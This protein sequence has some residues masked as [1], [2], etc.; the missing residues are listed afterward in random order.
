MLVARAGD[1]EGC[2]PTYR[3]QNRNRRVFTGPLDANRS[4]AML[5]PEGSGDIEVREIL[6]DV[7]PGRLAASIQIPGYL[8][9]EEAVIKD[10]TGDGLG[11]LVLAV[12]V[13]EGL[14]M[15]EALDD[16]LNFAEPSLL[17]AGA[18][19]TD[20]D[21]ADIDG[22]THVDIATLDLFTSKIA[23]LWGDDEGTFVE[24][25]ELTLANNP[26]K[27]EIAQLDGAGR[28]DI[29]VL[30]SDV[31]I[32]GV[33]EQRQLSLMES[34]AVP[35]F[36]SRLQVIDSAQDGRPDLLISGDTTTV[37]QIVRKPGLPAATQ[38]YS[39][40][41]VPTSMDVGDV[42]GDGLDDAVLLTGV[43]TT[44]LQGF[45]FIP[46]LL[47]PTSI[48]L[49]N[50]P[51]DAEL[52]DFDHDGDL[53]LLYSANSIQSARLVSNTGDGFAP[54]SGCASGT[55]F[56]NLN[57]PFA[58]ITDPDP[59]FTLR[60]R[61]DAW[62]QAHAGV[63]DAVESSASLDRDVLSPDPACQRTL[64]VELRDDLG[65]PISGA[66]PADLL[67]EHDAASAGASAI[68]PVESLG[69]GRFRVTLIGQNQTGE[70]VLRVTVTDPASGDRIVLMPSVNLLVRDLA[71]LDEDGDYDA[72][73]FNLWV[74]FYQARDS[75][76]DQNR[77]GLIT[78]AD[79]SAWLG[80]ASSPC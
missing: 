14:I 33:D 6:G 60:D 26:Y 64:T 34:H 55:Y 46:D 63:T 48:L 76:A 56:L 47:L 16:R 25:T 58:S 59:V 1:E 44:V 39:T 40:N 66:N 24:R 21:V 8:S 29:A 79:F 13:G 19:V 2:A 77:D 22:D 17:F 43:N 62:R 42:T 38:N 28:L 37:T 3:L 45:S 31:S 35:P 15:L 74:S 41:F 65:V 49:P 72:D 61:Y 5:V 50:S 30:G 32:Y 73:D 23:V 7:A 70:D 78:P 20:V 9:P 53:D 52:G 80:N 36:L 57:V 18:L 54:A 27:L 69:G 67:I 11:D 71:D 68:G 51:R 10:I 4:I 75:R 12:N